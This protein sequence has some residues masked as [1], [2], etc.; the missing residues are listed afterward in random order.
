MM[1][2]MPT[3]ERTRYRCD[4]SGVCIGTA[5]GVAQHCFDCGRSLFV[6]KDHRLPE[7]ASPRR[8]A[9]IRMVNAWIDLA[10][11]LEVL[12]DKC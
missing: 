7:H 4:G 12:V 5:P 6:T 2:G 11:H 3:N 8:A 1:P 9:Q 10:D